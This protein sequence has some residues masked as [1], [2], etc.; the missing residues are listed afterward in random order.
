VRVAEQEGIVFI[1]EIDK[2]VNPSGMLRHG[3]TQR[4]QQQPQPDLASCLLFSGA[5]EVCLVISS[6]YVIQGFLQTLHTCSTGFCVDCCCYC[7]CCS[8]LSFSS[9]YTQA[10]TP[11]LRG[12]SVTCCP[13]LR[14]VWCPQSTAQWPPTTCCSSPVAH[15]Q[16]PSPAT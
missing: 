15:S 16:V 14:A 12:C 3:E 4:Q 7:C 6:V 5:Q 10:L 13:S 9:P 2:I 1:D 8:T 11:V